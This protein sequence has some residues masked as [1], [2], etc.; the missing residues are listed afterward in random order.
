[1]RLLD[2]HEV[3]AIV[4]VSYVTLWNWMRE[5]RFPRSRVAGGKVKWLE[6]EINDWVNSLPL[7]QLK[8]DEA[9]GTPPADKQRRVET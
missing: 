5:G 6:S 4:G 8:G 7:S 1:M 2:R 9:S 3:C